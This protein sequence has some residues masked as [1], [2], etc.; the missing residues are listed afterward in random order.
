[1][2]RGRASALQ[3]SSVRQPSQR[4]SALLNRAAEEEDRSPYPSTRSSRT[5]SATAASCDVTA[6]PALQR[7]A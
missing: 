6:A 3:R 4:R 7:P 2:K 1:M 5:V